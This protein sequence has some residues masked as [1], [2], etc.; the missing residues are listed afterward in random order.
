MH[1]AATRSLQFEFVTGVVWK[2]AQTP[3]SLAR[4]NPIFAVF[5]DVQ[6]KFAF[7]SDSPRSVVVFVAVVTNDDRINYPRWQSGVA[8]FASSRLWRGSA[9]N[10]I[11]IR[12]LSSSRRPRR[13]RYELTYNENSACFA[14]SLRSNF[15]VFFAARALHALL[16]SAAA[17]TTAGLVCRRFYDFSS[18]VG[19][20]AGSADQQ[21]ATVGDPSSF[22]VMVVR[23]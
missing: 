10:S 22:N 3:N 19:W 13:Q 11:K 8:Y 16:L 2:S 7:S 6:C 9:I 21:R 18:E 14:R 17:A 4:S 20:R 1:K 15:L 5:A 12:K 23:Y